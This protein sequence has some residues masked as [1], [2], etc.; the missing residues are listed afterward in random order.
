MPKGKQKPQRETSK[1][2]KTMC[3]H[4]PEYGKTS[5]DNEHTIDGKTPQ[6]G[7]TTKQNIVGFWDYID[8]SLIYHTVK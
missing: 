1:D 2:T 5:E 4:T 7:H 8:F 6:Y 3:L